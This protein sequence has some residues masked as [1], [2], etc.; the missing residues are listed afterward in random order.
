MLPLIEKV[1]TQIPGGADILHN[2]LK[3][4]SHVGADGLLTHAGQGNA[5]LRITPNDSNESNSASISG[6]L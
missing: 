2:L 1:E 6:E 4:L 5:K 3:T